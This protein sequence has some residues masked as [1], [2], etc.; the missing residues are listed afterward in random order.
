[1][2]EGTRYPICRAVEVRDNSTTMASSNDMP[3]ATILYKIR[4]VIKSNKDEDEALTDVAATTE[5]FGGCLAP[6][7]RA[8]RRAKKSANFSENLAK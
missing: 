4:R 6:H 8:A 7:P 1:V 2:D 3:Y 5:P